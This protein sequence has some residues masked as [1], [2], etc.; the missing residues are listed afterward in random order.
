[1]VWTN[2]DGTARSDSPL[3]V[4]D[5]ETRLSAQGMEY[6]AD[7]K[8]LLLRGVTGTVSLEAGDT[9]S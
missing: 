5:G 1:M 6:D 8:T 2:E 3:S 9:S 4:H 7:T